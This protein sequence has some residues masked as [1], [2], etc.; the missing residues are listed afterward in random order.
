ME[1]AV[2]ELV[3]ATVR[4]EA[5]PRAYESVRY[6]FF[7]LLGRMRRQRELEN[8]AGQAAMC[9]ALARADSAR[10]DALSA[11]A[12]RATAP[13][14]RNRRR[15][16]ASP[17]APWP[18]AAGGPVLCCSRCSTRVCRA[19]DA[20]P[21]GAGPEVALCDGDSLYAAR[22]RCNVRAGES[23]RFSPRTHEAFEYDARALF[24][25]CCALCLGVELVSVTHREAAPLG[26]DAD[27]GAGAGGIDEPDAEPGAEQGAEQRGAGARSRAQTSLEAD[28]AA[29]AAAESGE[30]AQLARLR[31]P[32]HFPSVIKPTT[33]FGSPRIVRPS[34]A[35]VQACSAGQEHEARQ[36]IAARSPRERDDDEA[37][38]PREGEHAQGQA[39]RGA[40]PATVTAALHEAVL[41]SRYLSLR[42]GM[43]G[44][45][46]AAPA[47]P[48]VCARCQA[49][50][51]DSHDIL[52]T[53]RTWRAADRTVLGAVYVNALRA[54]AGC[55]ADEPER[56]HDLAQGQ[57][58]MSDIN[59]R[60]GE[61]VGYEFLKDL[62]NKGEYKVG[63]FGLLTDKVALIPAPGPASPPCVK[64]ARQCT[65]DGVAPLPTCT[66]TL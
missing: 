41:C 11:A 5:A 64:A 47:Q 35:F 42:D 40:G 3:T 37:R 65:A 44:A 28:P 17:S 31:D 53:K 33:L 25:P 16:R 63:R 32:C 49:L 10:A 43:S 55:R 39:A 36:Y 6:V 12:E 29:A 1:Q 51:A 50:L 38:C 23:L 58:L 26:A 34:A 45:P 66:T 14:G 61:L 9:A 62:C 56:V 27:I 57:F 2:D 54:G 15:R 19:R 59:C 48:I 20:S 30:A 13:A 21:S 7:Q 52:C 24:C 46:L 4:R 8:S 22:G 18:A 60:C